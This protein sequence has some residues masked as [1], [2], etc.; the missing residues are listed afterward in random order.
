MKLNKKTAASMIDHTNLKANAKKEDIIELCSQAKQYNFAS[1]CIHPCH[2]K[3]A[4]E[5]LRGTDVMVAT[6]AGFPLGANQTEV[7]ASEAAAAAK[8]GAD[9]I[10]MVLNI[11]A[12][13]DGD[14]DY[15]E[16][17]IKAVVEAAGSAHVKVIIECCYLTNDE[18]TAACLA[19]KRAGA[20]FVK[21]ST[22]MADWGAKAEDVALM[23]KTVG[24][25]MGV[26]AAGGIRSLADFTA[27]VEAGANRIGAS[28]G[29][30]IL[31]EIKE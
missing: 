13:K 22:G 14:I 2:I 26:K 5:E 6:V 21:T 29:M 8:S 11:G 4:V 10:D 24:T 18:M 25:E 16:A 3:L 30:K 15:V 12:L 7:K 20:A 17:D 1:V 19:S 23:R 28:S 31:S 27:M 9:E